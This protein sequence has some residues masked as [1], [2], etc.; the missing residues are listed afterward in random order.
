MFLN[1]SYVPECKDKW[2]WYITNGHFQCAECICYPEI[3]D[4]G[5]QEAGAAADCDVNCEQTY[6]EKY[7]KFVSWSGYVKGANPSDNVANMRGNLLDMCNDYM[8]ELNGKCH[9]SPYSH[10]KVACTNAK[11]FNCL[12]DQ[13]TP[14]DSSISLLGIDYFIR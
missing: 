5:F 2:I 9:L 4:A 12:E 8:T 1:F 14:K 13:Y 6:T 3:G 11:V 10:G 7:N